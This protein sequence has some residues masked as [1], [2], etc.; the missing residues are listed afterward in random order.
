MTPT[1]CLHLLTKIVE[2]R[3][4]TRWLFN[5]PSVVTSAINPLAAHGAIIGKFNDENFVIEAYK[6]SS[7]ATQDIRIVLTF[8]RA[9]IGRT[10]QAADLAFCHTE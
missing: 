5:S 6:A 9:A 10:E 4:A 7:L 2:R 8:T 1:A 3:I